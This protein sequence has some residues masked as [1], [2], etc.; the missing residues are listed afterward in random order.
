MTTPHKKPLDA[1]YRT[2]LL[3]IAVGTV[4]GGGA[5]FAWKTFAYPQIDKQLEIAIEQKMK[6]IS[7]ALLKNEKDH[8]VLLRGDADL[9]IM[10]MSIMTPEQRERYWQ[11]TMT[12]RPR[13]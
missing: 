8:E 6:P 7:E 2:C 9:K 12:R 13:P 5:V 11:S 4:V 3:I 1:I 10:I